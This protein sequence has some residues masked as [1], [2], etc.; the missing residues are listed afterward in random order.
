L[1]SGD[2][3]ASQVALTVDRVLMNDGK[4]QLYGSQFK[5]TGSGMEVVPIEDPEHLDERRAQMGLGPFEEYRAQ[6]MS[7]QPS[8]KK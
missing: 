3:L 8:T 1:R 7:M 2:L 5:F 6:I 4:K